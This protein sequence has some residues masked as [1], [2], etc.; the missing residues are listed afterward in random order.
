MKE[1][2]NKLYQRS[3]TVSLR[4]MYV[5]QTVVI[6]IWTIYLCIHTDSL[7]S[8]YILCAVCSL[9]LLFSPDYRKTGGLLQSRFLFPFLAVLFGLAVCAA[10][11]QVIYSVF[12][13]LLLWAGGFCVANICLNGFYYLIEKYSMKYRSKEAAP[14]QR[15]ARRLFVFCFFLI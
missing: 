10:N 1:L 5:L 9:C 6:L 11:Y 15:T 12:C 14:S 13:F 7:P 4:L 3:K 2:E 8:I